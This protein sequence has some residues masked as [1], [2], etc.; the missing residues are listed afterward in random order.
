MTTRLSRSG[1][2]WIFRNTSTEKLQNRTY[3]SVSMFQLVS[4][5]VLKHLI[6][7]T[8]GQVDVGPY[9]VCA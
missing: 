3:S 5:V 9:I 8:E 4:K 7:N 6:L 1:P 2:G